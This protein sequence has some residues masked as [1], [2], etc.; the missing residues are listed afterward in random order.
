M[1]CREKKT[2][3][4]YIV[5]LKALNDLSEDQVSKITTLSRDSN[6]YYTIILFGKKSKG[7]KE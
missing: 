3:D 7:Y 2:N 1:E 5:E 6:T 4:G